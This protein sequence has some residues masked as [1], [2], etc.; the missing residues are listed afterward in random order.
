MLVERGVLN[1]L[2]EESLMTGDRRRSS[3][4][5]LPRRTGACLG[6]LVLVAV[7]WVA[8]NGAAGA[9]AGAQA[10][11]YVSPTGSGSACT[12]TSPCSLTAAQT[13]GEGMNSNMSG[14]IVV[15]LAGATYL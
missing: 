13:A 4:F 12:S 2:P 8:L 11:L 7:S 10:T 5:A 14:Y 1:N 9:L 15:Q 3:G 6:V